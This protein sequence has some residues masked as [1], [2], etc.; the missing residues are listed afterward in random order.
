M[1]ATFGTRTN[2]KIIQKAGSCFLCNLKFLPNF[3]QFLHQMN[4]DEWEENCNCKKDALLFLFFIIIFLFFSGQKGLTNAL[5]Y[6]YSRENMKKKIIYFSYNIYF[7]SIALCCTLK[8]NKNFI[9]FRTLY[10]I[11]FKIMHAS[12]KVL[13][14]IFF[15]FEG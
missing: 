14:D 5:S 3:F 7:F 15:W 12:L 6:T 9:R 2:N 8:C 13:F 4:E 11:S 10:F 1:L